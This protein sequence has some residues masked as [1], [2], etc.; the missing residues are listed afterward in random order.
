[1]TRVPT[2]PARPEPASTSAR[3]R[4]AMV[5]TSHP[6]ATDAG[7]AAL[8]AGGCAVDAYIAAAAVQTVVEPT[9]TSLAGGFFTH[10]YEPPG[11]GESLIVAGVSRLPAAEDGKVDEAGRWSGRTV[12]V[13]GWVAGAHAA[14]RKW[15]KLEWS[16]LL[17]QALVAA[18]EG[19]VVDQMLW[20][21]LF[22][23][24]TVPGRYAAGRDLWFPG[25]TMICAGEL[26]RQPALADT[27]EQVAEQ[28]PVYFY[29]GEFARR[30]V[31]TAR[32]AGGRITRDDMAGAQDAV[33]HVIFPDVPVVSG[34]ELQTTGPMLALMLNLVAV[35]G[36]GK[37]GRPTEDPETLYLLLRIVE[38][39]WHYGLSV[40]D[41]HRMPPPD[42]IAAAFT[43]DAAE[44]I[45]PQVE[46][47]RPR[48]FDSMNLGTNAIVAVDES[49][50]VAHGTHSHSSTPFGVGLFVDGVSVPRPMVP[51]TDPVIPIPLGWGSSVLALRD[52]RPILAAGSPAISGLQNLFQNAA[53]VLEWGI[54][55]ADSVQQPLFGASRYPSRRPMVEAT[56]GEDVIAEVERRGLALMP[57]SPWETDM[58]SCQAISVAADGTIH[59]V[60]DPRRLGRAA[61]Y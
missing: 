59:G 22:A 43:I 24:R 5:S 25:G 39:S 34:Y 36:L 49:G 40:G 16:E 56:M 26:L 13:P 52:G 3:G 58:G 20:G 4:H 7:L 61:G 15:G 18:R 54:D 14:W 28:G 19:F 60:A 29:E 23:A 27:I 32:A 51:F 17:E 44:K 11:T 55:L 2:K 46:T 41:F 33:M 48:P 12:C 21:T 30:Y 47:G 10:V 45:W 35:G 50:M 38:E 9:A 6:A 8:R 53:N 37:R 31:D 57:V 1:M 42:E